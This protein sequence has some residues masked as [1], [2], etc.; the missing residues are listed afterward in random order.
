M[1]WVTDAIFVAGGDFVFESWADFQSQS[2]VSAVITVSA[3]GPLAYRDPLP[4]AALW[5]P[6]EDEPAYSLEQ[7]SLGV[8]FIQAA[9]S[10]GRKVLLHGPK[11]VHRTRPLVAGHL[12][13]SGKSLA[14]AL[15]EVE[16]KPWLPP[17]K[18]RVELLEGLVSA[19]NESKVSKG[20]KGI[21]DRPDRSSG[22]SGRGMRLVEVD[23][24]KDL[25]DDADEGEL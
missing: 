6:V 2:G 12:L 11:G 5:L 16:E 7:L 23:A 25:G 13:A 24:P 17:Y 22:M 1:T 15:R 9:L 4:W 8:S 10:A 21:E 19:R 14:R 20:S 18:G 3:E